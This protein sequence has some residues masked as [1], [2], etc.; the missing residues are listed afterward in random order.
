MSK[1]H[2]FLDKAQDSLKQDNKPLG[3]SFDFDF[4]A[5]EQKGITKD[6]V[7]SFLKQNATLPSEIQALNDEEAYNALKTQKFQATQ[8]YETKFD[9]YFSKNSPNAKLQTLKEKNEKVENENEK[10]SILDEIERIQKLDQTFLQKSYK[11]YNEEDI[12]L[13]KS[14]LAYQTQTKN[15]DLTS[16]QKQEKFSELFDESE[17]EKF[18]KDLQENSLKRAFFSIKESVESVTGLGYNTNFQQKMNFELN[19]NINKKI[20]S[21]IKYEDLS[22]TEKTFLKNE[23]FKKAADDLTSLHNI[24]DLSDKAR[25]FKYFHKSSEEKAKIA[26]NERKQLNETM[27]SNK[28]YDELS[29]DEKRLVDDF[30]GRVESAWDN[31]LGNKEEAFEELKQKYEASQ[32][33]APQIQKQIAFLS[34]IHKHKSLSNQLIFKD[35]EAKKDYEGVIADL[36]E[37]IGFEGAFIDENTNKLYF[38]KDN[39]DYLVNEGFFDNFLNTLQANAGSITGG[40]Y[41]ATKGFKEGKGI[42]GKLIKSSLGAAA[43]S[44]LG[45][46]SDVL[47]A[48]HLLDRENSLKEIISHSTE[49][50]LLSLAG[51]ALIL[52]AKPLINTLKTP[53]KKIGDLTDY[54]PILGTFKNLPD[55]NFKA[56]EEI[57]NKGYTETQK[58][59]IFNTY[60]EFGGKIGINETKILQEQADSL[61]KKYGSEHFLAKGAKATSDFLNL[62]TLKEKQNN[63]I[64]LIRADESGTSLAFIL[65]S[66]KNSP[67]VAKNLK[68][69]LNVTTSKLKSSL[70]NLNL[71]K[72]DIKE[73][74]NKLEKGT[75][76]SYDEAIN[77]VLTKIYDNTY[78]TKINPNN[79]QA[80][81]SKLKEENALL[82]ES[83]KLIN[84]NILNALFKSEGVTFSQLNNLN[85]NLNVYIKQIS[86]PNLQDY[87][88]ST[89][90]NEIKTAIKTGIN[91]IF[92]QNKSAYVKAKALYE[93]AMNDY[94]DM[95]ELL[96]EVDK[97]KVR[98]KAI[99]EEKIV[100]NLLKFAK[101]QGD[102]DLSNIVRL[103]KNLNEED[104]AILEMNLLNR[105]FEKSLI[106][107][108]TLNLSVFDSK[109]FLNELSK[110]SGSFESKEAKEFL[111]LTQGFNKLFNQDAEIAK[112]FKQ[113]LT[114]K[115]GASIATSLQ[116]KAQMAIV[117]ALWENVIRLMGKVPFATAW[118]EKVQG[119]ALRY[120]ISHALKRAISVDDF[121]NTLQNSLK[122]GKFNNKTKEI[123]KEFNTEFDNIIQKNELFNKLDDN[124][125]L[126]N[127]AEALELLK[128]QNAAP[129]PKEINTNEFLQSLENVKNKENFINHLAT[130]EDANQ[131]LAYLNLVEPT[132]KEP[133]I[134][135][136]TIENGILKEKNIKKFNDGKDFFYLLATKE[137]GNIL[138]TGFK[139]NKEN[140]ILK[141][142][143]SADI[144]QTFIRQ[145]SKQEN[146][147]LGLP[148]E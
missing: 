65:E 131:R 54:S 88:K 41:G 113:S 136:K 33:I 126:L 57:I 102:G 145:G 116:G 75:K 106:E 109:A 105:V 99:T 23:T 144:I 55:Q 87:L 101:G 122:Q 107:N 39:K 94:K 125:Q 13:Y 4:N 47:I 5:A 117:K 129:L 82:S 50:G 138:L 73:V 26:F 124:A 29:K 38:R 16:Q 119:A 62:S 83:D 146:S 20:Q 139:T 56:A 22:N 28:S 104:K 143:E 58:Q 133:D 34:N 19:S 121:R 79:F 112:A 17:Y 8:D 37:K 66:A 31:T 48:N 11:D 21:G 43:G 130:R 45:G 86:D 2:D 132:L 78:K 59:E 51:D 120:H 71:N 148:N 52:G 32:I 24:F 141:E 44:F 76:Q 97:L 42:K 81:V 68:N 92:S 49:E 60:A 70:D 142:L 77:G 100:D 12:N 135:I 7:I 27:M 95:K 64:S 134:Q 3:F 89:L 15:N 25:A 46:V 74:F 90:Q 108:K 85:K 114:Q 147:R 84:K 40:F 128:N 53:L 67:E 18:Y 36:V 14:F 91:D 118:N 123:I 61:A 110:V 80:L 140:T 1:T 96:K 98:D 137:N 35:E 63:L 30:R 103:K 127:K 93:N 111:E 10:K 69:V 115:E 72:S 9:E 6:E